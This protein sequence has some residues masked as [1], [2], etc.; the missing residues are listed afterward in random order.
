METRPRAL[1]PPLWVSPSAP[2]P[3]LPRG[4]GAARPGL[5][6]A[7]GCRAQPEAGVGY[8]GFKRAGIVPALGRPALSTGV[9]ELPRGQPCPALN[10]D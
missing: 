4:V 6:L 8:L 3:A 9:R 10:C 7:G 1:L 5:G 2:G